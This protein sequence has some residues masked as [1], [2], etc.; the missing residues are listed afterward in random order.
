[1]ANE[2][3]SP[4]VVIIGSGMGGAT[5]AAGLAWTGAKITILERGEYIPKDAPARDPNRI[6]RNSAF[7][8]DEKWL[9]ERGRKFA[10]GNYYHVGGNS[11][12]Y[13][14]VLIRYRAE[15]FEEMQH[16]DG[17][18]PAWPFS[19]ETLAPWYDAAEKMYKV[20][21]A[22]GADQTEP[23]HSNDYPFP[24]VPDEPAIAKVR[25]RLHKV[26][27]HTF[28]LPLGVDI[29]RWLE[30][31]NTGWDGYPDTCGGKMDAETCGLEV[32]LKHHNVSLLTHARVTGLKTSADRKTISEVVYEKDGEYHRLK[33]GCVVLCAGAVQSAALL[34]S[35]G[36]ANL[37]DQVGRC[38]MNHNA[39]ALIA[40][41]PGFQNDSVYQK[42]F[43]INDWYLSDGNG[44]PP[45]GNIQLLGRVVPDIL[46]AN[47]PLLPMPIAR[48]ISGHAVDLYAISEDLPD[49]ESRVVLNGDNIQLVWRRSNMT[50]H[51]RLVRKLKSTLRA[52][53]FPVVLSRLFDGRVPSHQCGT[54]R[55]GSDPK[56]SVL[57]PQCRSWDHSNLFVADAA[58]LPTSAAVN[59]ALSVAAMALRTADTIKRE[60]GA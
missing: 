32:A 8:S 10:P 56:N 6:F 55:I 38:F 23:K 4:D 53:G 39:S 7:S 14:A 37:S 49:P 28:S 25:E 34:L 5:L 2:E 30:G 51:R 59:P 17:V 50:A 41:D 60:F 52:A 47:V 26:G 57:D 12:L 44:G 3:S 29:D 22:V 48:Y 46:N 1:M 31:G 16:A 19:Y 21:G 58:C 42:T 35:N 45:L 24:P 15:D 18:S 36:L 9:D 27:A 13:G 33:P 20:R 43:G 40:I 11:K 54:A